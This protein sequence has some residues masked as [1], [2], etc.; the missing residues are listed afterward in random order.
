MK[1]NDRYNARK[2]VRN[3]TVL[4]PEKKPKLHALKVSAIEYQHF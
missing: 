4:K 2:M 1:G 3:F